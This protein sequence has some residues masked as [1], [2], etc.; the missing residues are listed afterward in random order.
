VRTWNSI[1]K[2][3]LTRSTKETTK[4]DARQF[5]QELFYKLHITKFKKTSSNKTFNH[6]A[7]LLMK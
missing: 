2:K 1:K 5:A 7:N 3:Y 4:I 6:F